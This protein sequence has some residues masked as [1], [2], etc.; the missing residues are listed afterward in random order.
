MEAACEAS[1]TVLE[2]RGTTCIQK[3]ATP[4][5]FRKNGDFYRTRSTV[6]YVGV[7][8]GHAFAFDAKAC[9]TSSFPLKNVHAH[10]L[11]Y[12]RSFTKAGG[13]GA[14]LIGF[15]DRGPGSFLCSVSW[16]D[17]VVDELSHRSSV[18]FYRFQIAA[19]SETER[20]IGLT[21]GEGGVPVPLHLGFNSLIN[22]R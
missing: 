3:I 7:H 18:P 9:A 12:L 15:A 13:I 1:L 6:D 4:S 21:H 19:L 11:D 20:C 5:G 2:K 22:T 17:D 16:W 8:C 14:L 10:Q